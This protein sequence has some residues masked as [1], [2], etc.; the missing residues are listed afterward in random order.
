MRSRSFKFSWEHWKC[1]MCI[2]CKFRLFVMLNYIRCRIK[3]RHSRL[4]LAF[5]TYWNSIWTHVGLNLAVWNLRKNIKIFVSEWKIASDNN[6]YCG[7]VLF[8]KTLIDRNIYFHRDANFAPWLI[9]AHISYKLFFRSILFVYIVQ[10][11]KAKFQH[12]LYNYMFNY[13]CT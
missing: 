1:F 13:M 9:P 2:N 12:N 8:K 3:I 11:S 4:N 6:Y 7:T 5:W 10:L